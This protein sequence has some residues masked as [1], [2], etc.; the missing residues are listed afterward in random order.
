MENQFRVAYEMLMNFVEGEPHSELR[1]GRVWT[2]HMSAWAPWKAQAAAGWSPHSFLLL[3]LR[4]VTE[5]SFDTRKR[6]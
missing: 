2:E 5:K 6:S 3:T 1:P 4:C